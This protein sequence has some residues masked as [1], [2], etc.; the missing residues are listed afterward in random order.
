MRWICR[1]V[2]LLGRGGASRVVV[3]VGLLVGVSGVGMSQGSTAAAQG[4]PA[5]APTVASNGG[6][7]P[8]TLER[9]P[10]P[11]GPSDAIEGVS[12]LSADYCEAVGYYTHGNVGSPNG[13]PGGS[14]AEVWDGTAWTIQSTPNLSGRSRTLLYG[15]SCVSADFCEAVGAAGVVGSPSMTVAEVWDGST[16]AIQPSAE[17]SG[18]KSV[19]LSG[20]SCV[21]ADSC[22]A[23]GSP[24]VAEVWNGKK[25]KLQST[26]T[27]SDVLNAVSCVSADDCEAVGSSLE[28][29][30]GTAWTVQATA[31]S[32]GRF[33]GVS[34]VSA[35]DCE[36]VGG[37]LASGTTLPIAESWD[38]SAWSVQSVP[39]PPGG[40]GVQL[41]SVSCGGADGCE[42]VGRYYEQGTL[43]LAES[44]DGTAWTLQTAAVASA[45]DND[46]LY[47]VSCAGTSYCE[48]GG[49]AVVLDDADA[50]LAQAWDGTTWAVQS[51]PNDDVANSYSSLAGVSCVAA[52]DC[53]AVGFSD[54]SGAFIEMWNGT[55]WAIQPSPGVAASLTGVS[56][57]A[58]DN[59]EAVGDYEIN[60]APFAEGWDGTSWTV[61]STPA[62][63]AS[64]V[65]A[66][67][68]AVSCEG[69]DFCE[70][71]GSY[72]GSGSTVLYSEVWDGTAW[73]VQA[74]PPTPTG[75]TDPALDSVSC[76][77]ADACEAVGTYT[78]SGGRAET[79]AEGWDGSAWTL[80]STP[81][82]TSDDNF[83]HDTLS[84][85]SCVA[86]DSCEAVGYNWNEYQVSG[87]V[88][89]TLVGKS[90]A[91]VWD[92]TAWTLQKIR[93]PGTNDS[94]KLSALSC[95][96]ANDCEAVGFE[97]T[98]PGTYDLG[99][100][101]AEVWDG[102]QWSTQSTPNPPGSLNTVDSVSCVAATT[103]QA[104][105]GYTGGTLA[106]GS[107]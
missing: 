10:N 26:A 15:V 72:G 81:N 4:G 85:V 5:G 52:D 61:Q 79:L 105:G 40:T 98:T 58:A 32:D 69:V 3:A 8:W 12:C 78:D 11:K 28:V 49:Y 46:Q 34:C 1:R 53:E 60:K 70:A 91:E 24:G 101:L 92:G 9:T 77:G 80:Q 84:G 82:K 71:V 97:D 73:A 59:C 47:G 100:M 35:D 76:S 30:N 39:S 22:E 25:W 44:W 23:V 33:D 13:K 99:P 31:P 95:V 18:A 27:T 66:P 107:S 57:V 62:P 17:V 90:F 67:L 48:A 87:G 96:T 94:P 68:S 42:A 55:A 83:D 86:A 14:L 106:I 89:E 19:V 43:P 38:G 37:S 103:C 75:G 56:C 64:D 36:A 104:V 88:Y 54:V 41:Q 29:W 6:T 2:G 93:L 65:S 51:T 7:G 50:T 102:T 20:V 21:A 74:T 16:W 45:S 63:A